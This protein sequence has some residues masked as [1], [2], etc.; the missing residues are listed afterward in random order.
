MGH[1]VDYH[2]LFYAV[3]LFCMGYQLLWFA[4]FEEYFLR[5]A[6][7]DSPASPKK[8]DPHFRLERWLLAGA[9][10]ALLGIAVF[11][12]VLVR[13]WLAGRGALLAV[14]ACTLGLTGV[15]TGGLTIVNA[16]ML[17]MLE[18]RMEHR[19]VRPSAPQ[20]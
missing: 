12:G 13:W 5:F 2:H 19:E 10:M 9:T 1:L 6:G 4:T 16:L 15:M 7:L 18:L 3:P 17:S 20:E 14:R 11:V 8:Q